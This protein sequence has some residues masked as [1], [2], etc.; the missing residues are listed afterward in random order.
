ME[1]NAKKEEKDNEGDPDKT[2]EQKK[3]DSDLLE[4]LDKDKAMLLEEKAKLEW[5]KKVLDYVMRDNSFIVFNNEK[6]KVIDQKDPNKRYE[7]G[8]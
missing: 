2:E 1:A 4:A 8:K 3:T 6:G 5:D 7:D